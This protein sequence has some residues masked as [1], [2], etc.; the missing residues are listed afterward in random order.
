MS[1][2]KRTIIRSYSDSCSPCRCIQR[3]DSK[4]SGFHGLGHGNS[5]SNLFYRNIRCVLWIAGSFVSHSGFIPVFYVRRARSGRYQIVICRRDFLRNISDD[6]AFDF[7][8]W[9][10]S[11]TVPRLHAEEPDF[12]KTVFLF[13]ELYPMEKGKRGAVL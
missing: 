10:G 4:S 6:A 13:M 11:F 3:E 5:L 12:S 7:H 9:S 8:F 1:L 2:D